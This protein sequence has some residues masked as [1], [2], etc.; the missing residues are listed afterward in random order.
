M[1][2][3]LVAAAYNEPNRSPVAAPAAFGTYDSVRLGAPSFANQIDFNIAYFVSDPDEDFLMFEDINQPMYGTLAPLPFATVFDN[4]WWRYTPTSGIA[5]AGA[6]V[7]QFTY[8]V[9]D[10][11]GA[12]AQGTVS[13]TISESVDSWTQA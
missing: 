1:W 2:L 3:S 11:R 13:I 10:A 8:V 7:E 12:T 5:K 6:V 9:S 4:T